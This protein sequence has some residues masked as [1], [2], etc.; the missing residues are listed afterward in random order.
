LL[1]HRR[2]LRKSEIKSLQ[3]EL[4][5]FKNVLSSHERKTR[6]EVVE[7]GDKKIFLFDGKPY[8]FEDEVKLIPTL[9]FESYISSAPKITVDMGAVPHICNGA[10]VMAPGVRSVSGAFSEGAFVVVS[11]ELHGKSIAVGRALFN[12]D[13]LTKISRGAVV[14]IHHYVGDEIYNISKSF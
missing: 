5:E 3:E 8:L 4:S 13:T 12:S 6:L 2:M 1:R 10:D 9:F 7:V 11:D 14:K